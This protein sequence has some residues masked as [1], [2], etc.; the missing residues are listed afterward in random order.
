MWRKTKW[1]LLGSGIL[2][3]LALVVLFLI[4]TTGMIILGYCRAEPFH[5]GRPVRFWI[6]PLNSRDGVDKQKAAIALGEMGPQAAPAVP[7]PMK[8][9]TDPNKII[10]RSAA[11]A[12][13][14]FG[15][16][17]KAALPTL[18]QL[19]THPDP[20]S[21]ETAKNAIKGIEG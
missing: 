5:Q 15:P 1:W 17:A 6:D 19:L 14:R 10:S 18:R 20:L 8:S 16:P 9:L 7:A 4:P 2:V 21:V 13:G 3:L 12:L 11:L